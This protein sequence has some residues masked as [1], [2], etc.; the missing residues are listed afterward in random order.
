MTRIR[1]NGRWLHHPL[2]PNGLPCTAR[3]RPAVDREI[4]PIGPPGRGALSA[5]SLRL[6]VW[7]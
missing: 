5:R 6:A 2:S 7:N 1:F 3:I 4:Q